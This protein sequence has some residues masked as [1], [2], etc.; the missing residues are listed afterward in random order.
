MTRQVSK[1]VKVSDA[2]FEWRPV[3]CETNTTTNT[4]SELQNALIDSGYRISEVDGTM[5][6]DTLRAVEQYQRANGMATGGLTYEVLNKL[7]I[8]PG[9]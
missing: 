4:I 7:G 9:K 6:A 2:R 8:R 3:L 1:K 5:S